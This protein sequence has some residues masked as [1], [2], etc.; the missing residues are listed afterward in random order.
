MRGKAGPAGAGERWVNRVQR[1][2]R[3]AATNDG[4]ALCWTGL[5]VDA[6]TSDP[7][8]ESVNVL[9]LPPRVVVTGLPSA[10]LSQVICQSVMR[11]KFAVP[12][13]RGDSPPRVDGPSP[14]ANDE[15]T[16]E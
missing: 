2:R 15:R 8:A 3:A 10:D 13:P 4:C 5:C 1:G 6:C 14:Q 9:G 11:G 16:N 12:Q 7:G